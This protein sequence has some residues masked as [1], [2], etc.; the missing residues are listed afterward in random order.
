MPI[1]ASDKIDAYGILS[2]I[3]SASLWTR[4]PRR[5]VG[6]VEIQIYIA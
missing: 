1:I 4:H 3:K 6:Y 2:I 5:G